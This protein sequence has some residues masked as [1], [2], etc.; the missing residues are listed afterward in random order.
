M[1][2]EKELEKI[3]IEKELLLVTSNK[4]MNY[5]YHPFEWQKLIDK[6]KK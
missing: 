3:Q 2:L 4:I 1:D 5:S 6:Y